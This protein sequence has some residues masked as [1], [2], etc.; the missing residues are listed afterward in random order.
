M[1]LTWGEWIFNIDVTR[2]VSNHHQCD[3]ET[4]TR[5]CYCIYSPTKV[6]RSMCGR[7]Q[8]IF[9]KLSLIFPQSLTEHKEEVEKDTD[10]AFKGQLKYD[11]MNENMIRNMK[12]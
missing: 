11:C 4:K 3:V 1:M 2:L 7:T 8:Q 10:A 9:P 12:L 6:K 5:A